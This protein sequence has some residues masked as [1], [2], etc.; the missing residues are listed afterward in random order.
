LA[1]GGAESANA[2]SNGRF[3]STIR[4]QKYAAPNNR[5]GVF[6]LALWD[7]VRIFFESE[8]YSVGGPTGPAKETS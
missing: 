6:L 4:Q 8:F 2:Q 5:S 3:D 1:I 7:K